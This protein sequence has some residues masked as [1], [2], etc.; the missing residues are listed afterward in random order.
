MRGLGAEL[1]FHGRDFDDAREHCEQLASEHGYRYVHSGN[2]PLL[3]AGVGTETVEILAEQPQPDV[4]VVPVGGGSGAAGACIVAK[5]I[6]PAIRVIGV[7]SD[8]APAACRSWQ[9][10]RLVEDK[11][12]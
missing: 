6:N 12:G 9:V 5:A 1:V 11:R 4:I 3:M 10:R 8:A 7:Q 2:E